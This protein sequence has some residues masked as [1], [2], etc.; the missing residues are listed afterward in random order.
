MRHI[1]GISGGKDSAALAIHLVRQKR[2]DW[3]YFYDLLSDAGQQE[4]ASRVKEAE[5]APDIECF[6]TDTGKEL[7]EVYEYLDIL[8][9]YLDS[10]IVRLTPFTSDADAN[11]S[12]FDHFLKSEHGGL[13]PSQQQRWC[14]YKMKLKPMEKFVGKSEAINYVGIRADEGTRVKLSSMKNIAAVY[15]FI[16]DGMVRQD[17]FDLLGETAGIPKYYEWRSRSGCYFCFFQRRSEWLGL[18][19]RHPDLFKKAMAY[20]ENTYDE[21][22]G[23]MYTWNNNMTLRELE[24]LPSAAPAATN[25]ND[26]TKW[27]TIL[28]ENLEDDDPHDHACAVCSL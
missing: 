14:T 6:F 12:P 18:R 10:P 4:E 9:K 5:T 25:S 7:P 20:E 1:I 28:L 2:N 15:P 22:T 16:F 3:Q 13:L 23:R 26:R 11:V 24:K 19:D 27:Q 17:V 21:N 8:E